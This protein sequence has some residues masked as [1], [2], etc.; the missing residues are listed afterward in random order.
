MTPLSAN[1]LVTGG[2][3]FIGSR[4]VAQAVEQHCNVIVL[5]ALTYAGHRANL[6]WIAPTPQ[7]G[8]WELVEGSITDRA[9]VADLLEEHEIGHVVNIA[10]ES[11]VDNSIAG[12]DAFIDTNITGTFQLLEASR[13]YWATLPDADRQAF[14]FLQVSTDEVYGS[15]GPAGTFTEDSPLRPN[16][17]YSASKA[18][19]DHLVRA[20]F[21]TYGL[22]VIT[23]HCTNNYGPRQHPEKLIPAMILAALAGRPLPVYGDGRNIRD[24]IH[25]DD[26]CRGLWLALHQGKPGGVY[27]FGGGSEIEN[28]ALVQRLCAL[29]DA[30]LPLPSGSYAARIS[31]VADRPGHDR[32]YAIDGG[33]ARRELGFSPQTA[34]AAGLEATVDWYL[35]N[36]AWCSGMRKRP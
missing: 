21:E 24:W 7:G 14:R 8:R 19:G 30:R 27:D 16:S 22:P 13:A 23:C 29:L 36:Q 17:P 31:F 28:I 6:E 15:L 32:R 1:L 3:G 25:V 11:H 10:A 18:A 33:R 35:A 34:F 20:W 9:L 26:H 2:A 12:A 5:D 4:F